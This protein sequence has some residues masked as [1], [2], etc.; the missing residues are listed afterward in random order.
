MKKK[1]NKI[2]TLS[3]SFLFT[4]GITLGSLGNVICIGDDGHFKIESNCQ[5]CC[6]ETSDNC[7]L[8]SSKNQHDHHDECKGCS[9]L[10]L[11]NPTFHRSN[12]KISDNSSTSK[13]LCSNNLIENI[14]QFSTDFRLFSNYM[15]RSFPS[16]SSLELSSTVV[17]C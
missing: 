16:Q 4:T 17:I 10:S 11:Y 13:L 5:P 8:E 6:D 12:S 7:L 1:F 3:I 14:N 2:I 15:Y 9:D